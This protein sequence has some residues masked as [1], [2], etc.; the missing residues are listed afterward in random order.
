LNLEKRISTLIHLDFVRFRLAGSEKWRTNLATRFP[1]DIRNRYAALALGKLARDERVSPEILAAI[2]PHADTPA[3][4][5][6]VSLAARDVFF[7]SRPETLD[8]FLKLVLT[9]VG[10][11]AAS[12]AARIGGAE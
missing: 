8:D 10:D 11:A 12:P 2:A 3:F 9:K 5:D 6:A 7:R 4:I 1:D